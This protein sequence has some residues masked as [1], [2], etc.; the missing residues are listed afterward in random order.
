MSGC[1]VEMKLTIRSCGS[2]GFLNHLN[3]FQRAMFKLNAKFHADSSLYSLSNFE[4][5]SHTVHI[6]TQ[7]CLPPPL[8]STRKLSLFMRAHSSP[9]S[10]DVKLHQ[11]HTNILFILKW[12]D[13]FWTDLVYVHIRTYTHT[14]VYLITMVFLRE[15]STSLKLYLN[16]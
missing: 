6:L 3:S 13:F 15:G 9:L 11:S 16:F 4:C 8:T 2:C 10:L 7:W 14:Y 12:M 1:V 5:D